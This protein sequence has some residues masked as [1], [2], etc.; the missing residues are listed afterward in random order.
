MC[1][2]SEIEIQNS[3]ATA[4]T[5]MQIE[6]SINNGIKGTYNWTGNLNFMEKA[7]VVLPTIANYW[8]SLTNGTNTFLARIIS[9]NG[10]SD[11]YIHNDD[12]IRE[13]SASEV[14]LSNFVL[15]FTTNA[16]GFQSSYNVRDENGSILVQRSSLA[17]NSTY[18]DTFN[19]TAGCYSINVFDSNDDGLS[20]FGNTNGNGSVRIKNLIGSTLKIFEPNFG[21]GFKYS[22]TIPTTVNIDEVEL[23]QSISIY[24]NPASS[25][26]TLETTGLKNNVW[27]IFDGMGRRVATGR[28]L[29]EHHSKTQISVDDYAAGIYYLHLSNGGT[30]TVKKFTISK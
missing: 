22:F 27:N 15:E 11:Q 10:Q 5:S 25:R 21:D 20:F 6:Y 23:S 18:R 2:G 7:I 16:A 19:L 17:S 4:I 14:L 12:I 1:N 30:T 3:G 28:T 29:N 13:F 8:N 24:P 9:T 26:L